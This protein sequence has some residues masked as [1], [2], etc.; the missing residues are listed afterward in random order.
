MISQTPKACNVLQNPDS[1]AIAFLDPLY[2][3]FSVAVVSDLSCL[4][5]FT[6]KFAE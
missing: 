1:C 6:A 3:A 4:K 2:S 5:L